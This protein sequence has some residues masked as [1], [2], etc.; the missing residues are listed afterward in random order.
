MKN[1]FT[2][3]WL[4]LFAA[5][6]PGQGQ[7]FIALPDQSPLV[8]VRAV[9]RTGAAT[10]PKGKE[11]LAALTASMLAEGGTKRLTYDQVV[12]ALYPMA[13]N[14]S[15]QVD[16]EMTTF[17]AETH[18]D[19][20]DAFY[21]IFRDILLDPGWRLED[22]KRLK[23]QTI[24]SLRVNLR[25]NNDEELGKEVLYNAIYAG[26]PYGHYNRGK[27]SAIESITIEDLKAFW[28]TNY[29]RASLTVGLAG[30]YPGTFADQMKKDF[31]TFAAG[32]VGKTV[33]PAPAKI[34]GLN[35]HLVDKRTRS[36]AYSF[37]FPFEVKRGHPDYLALLVAQSFLGPHRN[38]AGLLY[39]NIRE[40]RGLNYGDYAYIEY[41]PNGMFQFEPSPNLARPQQI[42][43]IWIRPVELP[44][45][46][47]T[48]RLAF[49]EVEKFITNGLTVEEFEQARNY[50]SKNV[51]LLTKT[52]RAELGYA[53]DSA[54]YGIPEYNRY[55]NAG[56]KKLTAADVNRAIKKH[57]QLAN[58][59]VVAI[60]PDAEELKKKLL[61]NEPSPMKY[62]SEKPKE[63]L[64]EDKLIEKRGLPFTALKTR[65]IPVDT[66][67]E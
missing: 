32:K 51:N 60:T 6:W 21:S 38:S 58:M 16:K 22:L 10:D 61:S 2:L 27:V 57:L 40:T 37:G 12:E 47:F 18:V 19:N 55:V 44:T 24:N 45:A 26:H 42:F 1:L 11:G 13:V 17:S 35:L 29:T 34:S 54:F 48:L 50:V 8:T 15:H 14:I 9:F 33:R 20:L 25:A 7:Q 31:S 43:Q 39:Q 56:L 4:L 63:L 64:D 65:V 62:A 28:R 41:F 59:H 66:I 36:V 67:F 49:H 46:H 52:K 30:G 5:T 23:D 3:A 53:I